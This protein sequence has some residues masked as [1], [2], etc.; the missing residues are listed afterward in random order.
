MP[1]VRLAAAA[2]AWALLL[3]GSVNPFGGAVEVT[4][5]DG[6]MEAAESA[7]GYGSQDANGGSRGAPSFVE[8]AP[9]VRMPLVGI[10]LGV[11]LKGEAA[12]RAVLAALNAGIRHVESAHEYEN[13]AAIGAALRASGVP[14]DDVFVTSKCC[15]NDPCDYTYGAAWRHVNR[16]LRDLGLDYVDHYAVHVPGISDADAAKCRARGGDRWGRKNGDGRVENGEASMP[17]TNSERRRAVWRAME[18]IKEAGLAR[19]IGV[20]NFQRQHLEDILDDPRVRHAPVANSV[21]WHPM[22]HDVELREFCVRRGITLTAYGTLPEYTRRHVAAGKGRDGGGKAKKARETL[23]RVAERVG[24]TAAQVTL[25]WATQ[26]GVPVIPR[27]ASPAHLEQN[28]ASSH[29][30]L[31]GEDMAAIDGLRVKSG[32]KKVYNPHFLTMP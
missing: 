9:G 30:E 2:L 22:Y 32:A 27:S 11:H 6:V 15:H 3:D 4:L 16:T 10:G 31:S 1:R 19:S 24:A 23:E 13:E 5:P 26:R 17:G 21:E 7:L 12:R 28:A 18:E 8:I 14:R 20:S 25:R 29:L